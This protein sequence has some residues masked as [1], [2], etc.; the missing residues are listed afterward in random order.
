MD[1]LEMLLV[2]YLNVIKQKKAAK[3]ILFTIFS[4]FYIRYKIK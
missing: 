2:E 3:L 4:F 1:N